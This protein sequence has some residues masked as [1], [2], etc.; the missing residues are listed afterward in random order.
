M[1]K[2]VIAAMAGLAGAASLVLN[3]P[4]ASAEPNPA[5]CEKGYFCI[6]SGQN[7]T[8]TRLVHAAGNWSGSVTGR[9]VFNNGVA[10]PGADHIQLDWTYNGLNWTECFHYNT[11]ST[12]SS[13]NGHKDNWVG[14]QFTRAV[15]RGECGPGEDQPHRR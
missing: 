9:S 15:W 12:P 11:P 7:Q 2:S 13:S 4:G 8:G 3:A 10:F 5:G 1:R 6:W 14:V